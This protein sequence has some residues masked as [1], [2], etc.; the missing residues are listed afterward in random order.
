MI[1][2]I[3]PPQFLH[4]VLRRQIYLKIKLA[5]FLPE[6]HCNSGRFRK[7]PSIISAFECATKCSSGENQVSQND[8]IY[9]A[10]PLL[11]FRLEILTLIFS[12]MYPE[13]NFLKID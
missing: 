11:H 13:S 5:F 8:T 4:I 1:S 9:I 6:I 3:S 10:K 12:K 7:H 2:V